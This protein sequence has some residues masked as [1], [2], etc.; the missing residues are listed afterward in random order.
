[1]RTIR[2]PFCGN[3]GDEVRRVETTNTFGYVHGKWIHADHA[4]TC[5]RID[6]RWEEVNA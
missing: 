6:A 4:A 2:G 3:C 1:M 5:E